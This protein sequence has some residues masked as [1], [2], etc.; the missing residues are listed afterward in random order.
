MW[1]LP[2]HEI[3]RKGAECLVKLHFLKE[4]Y[5]GVNVLVHDLVDVDKIHA[6]AVVGDQLL[7]EWAALQTFLMAGVESL[8]CV[9]QFDGHHSLG[10]LSHAVALGGCVGTHAH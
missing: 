3:N 8:R 10:V 9:E 2:R 5:A 7:N 1:R 4:S 6:L